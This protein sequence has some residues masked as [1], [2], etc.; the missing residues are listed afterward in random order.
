MVGIAR[1]ESGWSVRAVATADGVDPR[2][3]RKWRDRFAAEGAAG[4]ADPSSR[5][6]CSP[7]RLDH[8]AKAESVTL[9]CRRLAGR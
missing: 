4:L 9:R 6:H 5:P 1:L 7:R 8:E 3:M 2:T